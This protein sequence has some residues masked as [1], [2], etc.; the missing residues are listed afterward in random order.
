MLKIYVEVTG[1]YIREFR[2]G[3]HDP[4]ALALL[5]GMVLGFDEHR[6]ILSKDLTVF[7]FARD[8]EL[9]KS[10]WHAMSVLTERVM[11]FGLADTQRVYREREEDIEQETKE[12]IHVILHVLDGPDPL[13]EIGGVKITP[14]QYFAIEKLKQ[15][16]K[17]VGE[18][19]PMP[20]D[21]CVTVMVTGEGGGQ[22]LIGIEANGDCHS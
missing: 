7:G 2:K 12:G 15:R 13:D 16:W 10:D 22:M 3:W 18:P 11:D 9:P 4:R 17:A 5:D 8:E 19:C 20:C 6:N 1:Y 21:D 14:E